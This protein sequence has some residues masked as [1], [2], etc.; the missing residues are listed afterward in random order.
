MHCI[1]DYL[2]CSCVLVIAA[3]GSYF[4]ERFSPR[5][6]ASAPAIGVISLLHRCARGSRR[7]C[8]GATCFRA[9]LPPAVPPSGDVKP[10]IFGKQLPRAT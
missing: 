6:W 9:F 3:F 7:V 10:K 4:A 2:H 5:P 8:G 1:Q